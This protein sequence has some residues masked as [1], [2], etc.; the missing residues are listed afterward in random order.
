[1]HF[2]ILNSPI[3]PYEETMRAFAAFSVASLILMSCLPSIDDPFDN[4]LVCPDLA[5]V[6]VMVTVKEASGAQEICDAS[7]RISDGAFSETLT[8]WAGEETNCTYAGAY[9]RPGNY[10][11]EVTH[12]EF[13]KGLGSAAVVSTGPCPA[14]I[15][16]AS[17]T[18]HMVAAADVTGGV[19]ATFEVAGDAD[20]VGEFFR[21]WV[22]N[23]TTIEQ[24]IALKA[25]T[26][27]ANIPNGRILRSPGQGGHNAP[28]GWHLDSDDVEM[29]EM[30]IEVCDAV[31]SYVEENI[32]EFVD[33]VLRFCPWG[34]RLVELEDYRD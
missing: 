4:G 5:A 12:A 11:I 13:A 33:N 19:L 9:N 16:Q 14:E 25:G 17:A 32:D 10:R 8:V 20:T 6:G 1:M 34:A 23:T 3:N 2:A 26:S 18:V 24:L 31:P 21:A 7:V 30:T 29:A 27:E 28:Y 15:K 22:T